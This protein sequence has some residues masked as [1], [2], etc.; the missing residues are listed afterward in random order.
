MEEPGQRQCVYC[1]EPATQEAVLSVDSAR[2]QTWVRVQA[3]RPVSTPSPARSRD[4][5][6][7]DDVKLTAP[8]CDSCS[9]VFLLQDGCAANGE[10]EEGLTPHKGYPPVSE[11]G[12]ERA[13]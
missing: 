1:G 7:A 4:A 5:S 13:R 12:S 11:S 3:T 6:P 9:R 10:Q 8:V 2:Q